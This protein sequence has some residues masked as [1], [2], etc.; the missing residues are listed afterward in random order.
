MLLGRTVSHFPST[1]CIKNPL[2]IANGY[3]ALRI[4]HGHQYN[5]YEYA[6]LVSSA[7]LSADVSKRVGF[8]AIFAFITQLTFFLSL[9]SYNI[10]EVNVKIDPTEEY[11]WEV[12]FIMIASTT[13]F[14]FTIFLQ[15]HNASRFNRSMIFLREEHADKIQRMERSQTKRSRST[16]TYARTLNRPKFYLTMNIFIK[17]VVGPCIFIFNVYFILTAPDPTNAVWNSV[18]LT[19]IM[20]IDEVFKPK[21]SDSKV[22]GLLAE[23]LMDYSLAKA[24]LDG[25][26]NDI[27]EQEE[28]I[29]ERRMGPSLEVP[30]AKFYVEL[31]NGVWTSND[32]H[33]I[34]EAF[35]TNVGSGDIM[36]RSPSKTGLADDGIFFCRCLFF[37]R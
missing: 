21:W 4:L 33:E 17:K 34:D 32:L 13:M 14:G 30:V 28:I 10:V 7:P 3:A 29:V 19:F 11:F 12:V 20:E 6:Y 26:E 8:M 16:Y 18:A 9:T 15:Y 35:G 23:L 31:L 27:E 25:T 1:E 36:I 24:L 2:R 37:I 22:E 5:V